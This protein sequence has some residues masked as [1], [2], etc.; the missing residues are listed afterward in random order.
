M[1]PMMLVVGP[2]G[3][4]NGAM[5]VTG[6]PPEVVIRIDSN[7]PVAGPI[8][9]NTNIG[10]QPAH[11]KVW[12]PVNPLTVFVTVDEGEARGE[13]VALRYWRESLDDLKAAQLLYIEYLFYPPDKIDMDEVT[14]WPLSVAALA[15]PY[16]LP[17]LA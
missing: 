6:V 17:T 10:L 4:A 7:P 14:G 2:T 9:I 15:R 8:E 5:D 1:S 16:R 13:T 11:S 12:D 3:S